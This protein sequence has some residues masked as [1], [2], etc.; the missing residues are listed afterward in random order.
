SVNRSNQ[1]GRS[2]RQLHQSAVKFVGPR[3]P[4]KHY[5]LERRLLRATPKRH[6]ID[7]LYHLRLQE[8][9]CGCLE[10]SLDGLARSCL[11][12]AGSGNPNS[13]SLAT[14]LVATLYIHEN[15]AG[16]ASRMIEQTASTT[17]SRLGFVK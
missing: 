4:G 8:Q 6:P 17:C 9:V 12:L 1:A 5:S 13:T 7:F 14:C 15:R 2:R 10:E 16:S 3:A 11:L